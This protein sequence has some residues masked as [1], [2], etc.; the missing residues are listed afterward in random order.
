MAQAS[1]E[2]LKHTGP[3]KRKEW[4]RTT[5]RAVGKNSRATFAK[6]KRNRAICPN[7]QVKVS[8]RVKVS[9]SR[10]LAREW[11]NGAGAWEGKNGLHSEGR[12][13][14]RKRKRASKK[15]HPRRS[16]RKHERVSRLKNSP[17]GSAE[18]WFQFKSG[19][20]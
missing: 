9:E 18:S 6:G 14:P 15:N 12:Q 2:A 10:T 16:R 13:I 19:Q 20:I 5:T 1:A 17:R 3:P 4:L 8:E 7:Y 11:G